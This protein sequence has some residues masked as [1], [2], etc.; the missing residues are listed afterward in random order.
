MRTNLKQLRL[1]AVCTMFVAGCVASQSQR[2]PE[3]RPNQSVGD[4]SLKDLKGR[5]IRFSDYSG[6]VVLLDFWGTWCEP[7][8]TELPQLQ[9]IW[10]R[11]QKSGFEL[12]TINVDPAD[13]ESLVR[14]VTKRYQYRFPVLLDQETEVADRFNPTLDLPFSLLIDKQGRIV[15]QHTGYRPGDEKVIEQH[16]QKLIGDGAP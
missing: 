12:V 7:C 10:Q 11:H 16:I 8:Q 6:K 13:N 14:Q 4:F 15:H 9:A 1:A 2:N 5:T 3:I